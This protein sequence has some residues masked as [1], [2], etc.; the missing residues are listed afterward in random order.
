MEQAV[1]STSVTLELGLE[2]LAEVERK[3]AQSASAWSLWVTRS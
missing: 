2:Y 3:Y 1:R